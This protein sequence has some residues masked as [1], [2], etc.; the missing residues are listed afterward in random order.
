[1]KPQ[2]R[3]TKAYEI[4]ADILSY[5]RKAEKKI[6]EAVKLEGEAKHYLDE[7][8]KSLVASHQRQWNVEQSHIIRKKANKLRRSHE[9][10]FENHIPRLS[11]TLAVFNTKLLAFE[12]DEG[13]VLQK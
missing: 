6:K 13:A 1:M 12:T 9:L 4:E 7:A 8:N 3:Y 5:K 2:K 10:I 11:R